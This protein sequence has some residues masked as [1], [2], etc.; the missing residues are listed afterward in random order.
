MGLFS[1][2]PTFANAAS[3]QQFVENWASR[4]VTEANGGRANP[5][6]ALQ[7]ATLAADGA[8]RP[9]LRATAEGYGERDV[10]TYLD[11]LDAADLLSRIDE[12]YART[13]DMLTAGLPGPSLRAR[14]TAL[15]NAVDDTLKTLRPNYL[16]YARINLQ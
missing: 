11:Q 9:P 3:K 10:V 4:V 6:G 13:V 14:R 1:R 12:V 5:N 16:D 2:T 7:L 15:D 8:V